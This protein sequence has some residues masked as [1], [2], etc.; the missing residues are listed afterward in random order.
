MKHEIGMSYANNVCQILLQWL[1]SVQVRSVRTSLSV[2]GHK[3]LVHSSL[4]FFFGHS[5]P[6][7][8]MRA[9]VAK[10]RSCTIWVH[11]RSTQIRPVE[12]GAWATKPFTQTTIYHTNI[13]IY[14]QNGL[15]RYWSQAIYRNASLLL[16]SQCAIQVGSITCQSFSKSSPEVSNQIFSGDLR[17]GK[18]ATSRLFPSDTV[19]W[20]YHW[21]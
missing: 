13:M 11:E 15:N 3:A 5:Q 6:K 18:I 9:R 20:T 8:M 7:S 14:R 4:Y 1:T 10:F 19:L 17:S 21:V 2:P 12:S 16:D